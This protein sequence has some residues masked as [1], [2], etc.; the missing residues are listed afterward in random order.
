MGP[1]TVQR[2]EDPHGDDLGLPVPPDAY[3]DAVVLQGSK[4]LLTLSATAMEDAERFMIDE[5][6][7]MD[8]NGDDAPDLVVF[9]YTGGAHCCTTTSIYAV[10]DAGA[11]QLLHLKTGNCEVELQ[12]LDNDGI[13]ELATCD[14][15]FAYQYCSFAMSGMPPVVY[16]Y[17]REQRTYVPDTPKY[18][19][20]FAERAKQHL[21]DARSEL[22]RPEDQR[23]FS[24][25]CIVHGPVADTIFLTGK[26]DAGIELLRTLMPKDDEHRREFETAL[27]NTIK[28]SPKFAPR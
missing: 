9:E 22:A 5:H 21:D 2:W 6:S 4:V 3:T 26:I 18:A 25:E 11:Q 13:F 7:G 17:D 1:L 28:G 10:R 23:E 12:D 16:R 27:T 19:A 20:A 14:D 15:I 24:P 8:I